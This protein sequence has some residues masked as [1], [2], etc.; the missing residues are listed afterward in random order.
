M[1][2]SLWGENATNFQQKCWLLHFQ[3]EYTLPETNSKSPWKKAFPKGNA[4]SNHPFSGA[5]LL[6]VSGRVYIY[7]KH[8]Q[9]QV[10]K[11]TPIEECKPTTTFSAISC[12]YFCLGVGHIHEIDKF[13]K[14]FMMQ[15]QPWFHGI[16]VFSMP[17]RSLVAVKCCAEIPWCSQVWWVATWHSVHV[18]LRYAENAKKYQGSSEEF[19]SFYFKTDPFIS[20]SKCMLTDVDLLIYVIFQHI[21]T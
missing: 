1:K 8:S 18:I 10:M 9:T 21:W 3:R 4:S 6:L 20:L 11:Q 13:Y 12:F 15:H 5:N 14:I 19:N 17:R 7:S 2:H 16:S